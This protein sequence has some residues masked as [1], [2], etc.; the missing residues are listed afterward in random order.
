MHMLRVLRTL[1]LGTCV[2]LFAA[3]CASMS[4][5]VPQ[6]EAANNAIQVR[7]TDFKSGQNMSIVN[8]SWLQG[9]GIAGEDASARKMAFYSQ[10]TSKLSAGVKVAEIETMQGLLEFMEYT[11]FSEFA[12]HGAPQ[13]DKDL[14]QSIALTRNGETRHIRGQVGMSKKQAESFRTT[15]RGFVDIYNRVPQFQSIKG[16]VD[17]KGPGN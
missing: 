8:D 7:F 1:L 6:G 10:I 12:T 5:D 4:S 17:F 3:S 14:R 13:A 16:A 9:Q 2:S 15:V 11:D